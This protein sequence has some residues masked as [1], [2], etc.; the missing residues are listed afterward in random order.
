MDKSRRVK[1]TQK[2]KYLNSALSMDIQRLASLYIVVVGCNINLDEQVCKEE[3][4]DSQLSEYSQNQ[5]Q[6]QAVHNQKQIPDSKGK[7]HPV[8]HKGKDGK[9][10]RVRNNSTINSKGG[11]Y[12]SETDS[13]SMNSTTT[14]STMQFIS[15][16]RNYD[17]ANN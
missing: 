16:T 17:N 3:S 12:E 15:Q 8:L 11:D 10:V 2:K 5:N 14:S 4:S 13:K 1:V 7:Y 9:Q 6:T